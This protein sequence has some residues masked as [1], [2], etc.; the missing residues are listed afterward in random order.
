MAFMEFSLHV[1]SQQERG[2]LVPDDMS[3]SHSRGY[4]RWLYIVSHPIVNPSSA[5][6]NYT[7]DA[8]PRPVPPYEEVIVEQQWA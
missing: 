4:M 1:L 3:W 7:A 2:D 5:I 6:P 8:H